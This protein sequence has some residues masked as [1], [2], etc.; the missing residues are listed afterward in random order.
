MPLQN[1][2]TPAGDIVATPARGIFTGNRGIIHDP[3]TK[4]LLKRRWSSPAWII[5]VCDFRGRRRAVMATRSWTELFF[6]DEATALAAGHRPCFYCR[7]A[8]AEA[9]RAAWAR[10]NGLARASAK[11]IDA[12]LHRERLDGRK[13]RL[14]PL[15]GE[16][17]S[18]PDGAMIQ[19]GAGAPNADDLAAS[20]DQTNSYVILQGRALL[21]SFDG[22][23]QVNASLRGAMLLTP[24]SALR[25]FGAGYAPVLHSSANTTAG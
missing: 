14:H 18:L 2:V 13:K 4:T 16:M 12:T 11:E 21:W 9:F 3:A 8:D 25:A 22:Y 7:R 23:R 19:A 1:R 6:L 15:P 24:P 17:E 20:S 10:G 5:C